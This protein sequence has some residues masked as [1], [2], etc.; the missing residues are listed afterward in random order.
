[1]L[2][3]IVKL[4]RIEG[5]NIRYTGPSCT[6]SRR[7]N[8]ITEVTMWQEWGKLRFMYVQERKSTALLAFSNPNKGDDVRTY[9]A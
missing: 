9:E 6:A 8:Y 1:M 7:I 2:R 5:L 4:S 3:I